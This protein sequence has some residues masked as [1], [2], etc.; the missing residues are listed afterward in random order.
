[1]LEL[2]DGA[3]LGAPVVTAALNV[4]VAVGVGVVTGARVGGEYSEG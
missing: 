3:E 2:S 4:G 1:M